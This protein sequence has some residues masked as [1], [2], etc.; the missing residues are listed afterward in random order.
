MS[1]KGTSRFDALMGSV[2][3]KTTSEQEDV[4]DVQMFNTLKHSDVQTSSITEHPDVQAS[5]S[6]DPAYQRTTIYL[7]KSMHRRLKAAAANE[8]KEMSA[9]VEE[10]IEQWLS[11]RQ[12][13]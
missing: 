1:K 8:E 13:A 6:K 2:R 3:A 9:I 12:D 5:K 4:A 7:P 11:L 10:L